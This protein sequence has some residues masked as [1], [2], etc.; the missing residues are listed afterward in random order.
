MTISDF[1]MKVQ[2]LHKVLTMLEDSG[3]GDATILIP[4]PYEVEIEL[5]TFYI[6]IYSVQVNSDGD[7]V[8][9]DCDPDILEN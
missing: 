2:D 4:A 5:N 1:G 3:H 9:L 8:T 6:P 7:I